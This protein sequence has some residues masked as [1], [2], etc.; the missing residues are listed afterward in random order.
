MSGW[1]SRVGAVVLVAATLWAV[2]PAVARPQAL[3]ASDNGKAQKGAYLRIVRSAAG[4]T[5]MTAV[6]NLMGVR[7]SHGEDLQVY[8]TEPGD[9]TAANGRFAAREWAG[10]PVA[11][12][13]RA[14]W[15]AA[16][17][18]PTMSVEELAERS[19]A[20]GLT[21]QQAIMMTQAA[22]WHYTLGSDPG[23]R[24]GIN[25]RKAYE[26]LI[27][28]A[29]DLP[30]PGS[31][32][33][34]LSATGAR[35]RDGLIGPFTVRLPPGDPVEVA[36]AGA[37]EGVHLF[38]KDLKPVTRAANGDELYISRPV[39]VPEAAAELVAGGGFSMPGGRLFTGVNRESASVLV[40][41][42]TGRTDQRSTLRF[43]WRTGPDGTPDVTVGEPTTTV[44]GDQVAATSRR[45][46]PDRRATAGPLSTTTVTRLAVE[47]ITRLTGGVDPVEWCLAALAVGLIVMTVRFRRGLR[48]R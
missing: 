14:A 43:G 41:R 2:P 15:V 18:Y 37:P 44:S 4:P 30:E 25:C 32:E 22:V 3:T 5:A 26:Y 13:G 46:E 28:N 8:T 24:D 34:S 9:F 12:L 39:D 21:R 7:T 47:R 40:A 29:R 36:L 23:G 38:T 17:G 33:M 11:N 20:A 1:S 31:G 10:A 35:E 45:A 16:N 27:S 48:R 6:A 19:G 42:S